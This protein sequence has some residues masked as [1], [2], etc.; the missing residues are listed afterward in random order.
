[1]LSASVFGWNIFSIIV[2]KSGLALRSEADQEDAVSVSILDRAK[3]SEP[4]PSYEAP[5][6]RILETEPVARRSG[7]YQ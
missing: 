6:E 2:L 4:E 5:P 1:M 7:G 3:A